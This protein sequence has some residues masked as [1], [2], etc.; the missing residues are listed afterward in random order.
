M[1]H[2]DSLAAALNEYFRV[3]HESDAEGAGQLF[4]HECC[5]FTPDA[6][7]T[8]KS[9]PIK[10]YLDVLRQRQSPKDRGEKRYGEVITIDQTGPSTAFVKVLSAVQ[11]KYFLDYLTFVR[12]AMGWRIVSK[13][14]REVPK[15]HECFIAE[16]TG[17]IL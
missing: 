10:A 13:V 4:H 12:D 16:K 1:Y 6:D 9:L 7:E 2:N 3:L 8:I 14:Y 15:P 17:D 11:P 5:L